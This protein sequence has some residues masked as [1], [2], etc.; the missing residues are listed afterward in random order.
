M[1]DHFTSACCP[2]GTKAP[3]IAHRF[4]EVGL[5]LSIPAQ[6]QVVAGMQL[7]FLPL[8]VSEAVQVHPLQLHDQMR[9]GM[10]T[11]R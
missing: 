11:A 1:P 2:E 3:K 8:Q 9:I 10:M 5:P 7:Y 6:Q 4:K